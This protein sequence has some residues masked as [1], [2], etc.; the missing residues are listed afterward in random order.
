MPNPETADI[1]RGIF[2]RVAAGMPLK[3]VTRWAREAGLRGKRGGVIQKSTV[4][5]IVRNPIYAGEFWWKDELS[6]SKDPP[7]ITMAL[8]ERVQDRLDAHHDTQPWFDSNRR[9][10]RLVWMMGRY[11]GSVQRAGRRPS[12]V[13]VGP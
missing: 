2:D 12:A 4:H 7:L 1:V 10:G 8:F 5:W 9:D 13:R 3:D 6:E 11:A